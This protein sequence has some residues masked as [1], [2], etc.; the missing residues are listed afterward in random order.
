MDFFSLPFKGKLMAGDCLYFTGGYHSIPNGCTPWGI[1]KD[2]YNRFIGDKMG[3]LCIA[4]GP[5]SAYFWLYTV[6]QKYLG[7]GLRTV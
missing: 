5:G 6:V 2:Y 4:Y 3:W 7:R 1:S